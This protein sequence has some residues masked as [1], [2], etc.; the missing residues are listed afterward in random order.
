MY[1]EHLRKWYRVFP[2]DQIQIVHSDAFFQNTSDVMRTLEEWIG[3]PVQPSSHWD[4]HKNF[5]AKEDEIK[6]GAK[7]RH[8]TANLSFEVCDCSSLSCVVV[9]PSLNAL[10][11]LL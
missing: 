2:R 3:L 9:K 5:N 7:I 11:E 1:Y 10:M 8:S 4:E 6:K